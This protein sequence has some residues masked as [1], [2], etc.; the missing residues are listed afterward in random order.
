[1]ATAGLLAP[2]LHDELQQGHRFI[3]LDLSR[4]SFMDCAGLRVLVSAHRQ[5][6]AARGTLVL[7]GLSPQLTRLLSCTHLEEELFVADGPLH[8][9]RRHLAAVPASH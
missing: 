5:F 1:M 3:R 9:R 6:L 8:R 7:T 2:A 4:L